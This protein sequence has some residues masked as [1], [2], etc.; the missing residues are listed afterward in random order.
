[1][2]RKVIV[3]ESEPALA[4]PTIVIKSVVKPAS[5]NDFILHPPE[6]VS[7]VIGADRKRLST[8]KRIKCKSSP[9]GLF[10]ALDFLTSIVKKEFLALTV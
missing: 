2:P 5:K 7:G 9:A 4:A 3:P 6:C 1:M 8:E 10:I